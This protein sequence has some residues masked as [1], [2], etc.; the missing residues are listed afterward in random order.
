MLQAREN[1]IQGWLTKLVLAC[2]PPLPHCN[3]VTVQGTVKKIIGSFQLDDALPWK[4]NS[5]PYGYGLTN[6]YSVDK[7]CSSQ[8]VKL[9]CANMIC[10]NTLSTKELVEVTIHKHHQQKYDHGTVHAHHWDV[11][12]QSPKWFP[13]TTGPGSQT[14]RVTMQYGKSL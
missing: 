5:M 2:E 4:D 12:L 13:S 1:H 14:P 3:K 7:H 9:R 11:S 8:P 10:T 6:R